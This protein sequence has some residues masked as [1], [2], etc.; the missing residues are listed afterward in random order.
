MSKN[1]TKTI[2]SIG[3]IDL[4]TGFLCST[5][6][7][8]IFIKYG[9]D[10][11]GDIAGGPEDYILYTTSV[12]LLNPSD[13]QRWD[14]NDV[15]LQVIIKTPENQWLESSLDNDGM[16]ITDE[17]FLDFEDSRFYGLGPSVNDSFPQR[18][19]YHVYGISQVSDSSKWELGIRYFSNR[20]LEEKRSHIGSEE[21]T[22]ILANEFLVRHEVQHI[23]L[24]N[25]DSKGPSPISKID[26]LSFG[27]DSWIEVNVFKKEE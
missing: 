20:L 12:E 14:L 27:E 13:Q 17:G 10:L 19:Y 23:G 1:G 18:H 8:M 11:G 16:K 4:L 21:V 6:A 15:L 26:T 3:F 2:V 5:V 7:L 25:T 9:A 22:A 24:S